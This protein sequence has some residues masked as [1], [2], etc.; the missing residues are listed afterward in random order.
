[1]CPR[2][3]AWRRRRSFKEYFVVRRIMVDPVP[4]TNDRLVAGH[5]EET[6]LPGKT[7]IRTEV[8]VMVRNE[9]HRGHVCRQRGIPERLCARLV[10][11]GQIMQE[12]DR[13]AGKLSTQPQVKSQ[14]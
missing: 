6:W 3:A 13:L 11:H 14:I 8:L 4:A 10:R 12:V 2:L 5:S 1:M 9:R 7:D